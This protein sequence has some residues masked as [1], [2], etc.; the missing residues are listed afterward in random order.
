MMAEES[1][2]ETPVAS[3]YTHGVYLR[4]E[5]FDDGVHGARLLRRHRLGVCEDGGV[6]VPLA[7]PSSNHIRSFTRTS[8]STEEYT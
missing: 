3:R 1:N 5:I 7:E 8:G 4:E 6:E 2:L